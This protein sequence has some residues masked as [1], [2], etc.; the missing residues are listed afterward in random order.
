MK[1][2]LLIALLFCFSQTKAQFVTIPDANFV[3][4]LQSVI[5]AAMNGNQMDTTS[6]SV[7]SLNSIVVGGD[8]ISNLTGLQYFDLLTSLDC[9]YN[10]LTNLPKLPNSLTYLYCYYNQLGSLPA[11][12]NSIYVLG[13]NYNQLTNLPVLPNLIE[14]INC[15]GNHLTSLPT[16]PI[17]LQSLDCSYNQLTNLPILPNSLTGLTCTNNQL[18]N[19]PTLSDSLQYLDCSYNQ[20]TNVPALSNNLKSLYCNNNQLV[21]LPAL[22]NSL[23]YLNCSYNQLTSLPILPNLYKFIC[24]NNGITCFPVFPNSIYVPASGIPM[25]QVVFNISSNPFTCLP[26]YIDVMDS[27]QLANPLCAA[28][29][30]N[31]C[32][33]A[34]TGIST[35]NTQNSIVK[36]YPNPAQNK[37]TIDANNVVDVKLFDVLGKQINSTKENQLDVSN[38]NDGV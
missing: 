12:P 26:N 16:L 5:P 9:S 21:S 32:P 30:S 11:L 6:A 8:S 28:G 2:L 15:S 31:G 22:P 23:K 13:C 24:N 37:I 17:T 29:N 10:N 27:A 18:A 38:L 1:K 7:T 35:F 4:Y 19:L 3:T 33:V 34:A 20:L 36:I 14:Q 25:P